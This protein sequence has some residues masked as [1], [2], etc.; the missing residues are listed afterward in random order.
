MLLNLLGWP[1]TQ[2]FGLGL[3]TF[4]LVTGV[5]PTRSDLTWTLL[6]RPDCQVKVKRIRSGG[7]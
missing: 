3:S 2:N 7:K 4:R 1:E 5:D 6:D